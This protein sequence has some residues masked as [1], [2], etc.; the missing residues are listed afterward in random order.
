MNSNLRQVQPGRL[1]GF[2]VTATVILLTGCSKP[3]SSLEQIRARGELRMV[4][5]NSPTSYY[6]G[7]HGPQG[8]EFRLATAF[9][10]ELGV[11][12]VVKTVPDAAAMRA[13]LTRGRADLAAAQISPAGGWREVGPTDVPHASSARA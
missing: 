2:T 1:V 4:T 13:A 3:S 12:L 10:R 9:A 11:A 8:F 7:A 5:V 6:L